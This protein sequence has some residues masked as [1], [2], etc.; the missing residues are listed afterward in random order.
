ML[1]RLTRFPKSVT[2][3]PS[4]PNQAVQ[5]S[6][7]PAVAARFGSFLKAKT[8]LDM[9]YSFPIHRAPVGA[10]SVIPTDDAAQNRQTDGYGGGTRSLQWA[11]PAH[12]EKSRGLSDAAPYRRY[13]P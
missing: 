7:S 5:A 9:V 13:L 2:A 4:W 1:A 10:T 6:S 3:S 11:E 8:Y 12:T